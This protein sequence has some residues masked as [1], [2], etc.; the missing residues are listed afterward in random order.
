M[1]DKQTLKKICESKKE[2]LSNYY[3]KKVENIKDNETLDDIKERF[4]N[5]GQLDLLLEIMKI[6]TERGRY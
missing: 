2:I 3:R 5:D 4:Y 1:K 6:C